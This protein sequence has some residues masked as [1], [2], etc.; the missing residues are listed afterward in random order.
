MNFPIEKITSRMLVGLSSPELTSEE[1]RLLAEY[2][3]AGVI[4]FSR[5]V[6]SEGQL[7][8][9]TSEIGEIFNSAGAEGSVICAD[10]EGGRI[11]VLSSAVGV[12]PSQM[13]M[14]KCGDVDLCKDVY[15]E[16]AGKVKALGINLILAPL[17]D[18]NIEKKN[19]VIGTRSFSDDPEVVS[20]LTACAVKSLLA[21]GVV[22]CVKHFPGHGGTSED[23]HFSLPVIEKTYE[24]LSMFEFTPFID[25][26]SAGV[27]A[28][29]VGHIALKGGRVPATFNPDVVGGWLRRNLSFNGVVITDALEME[30]AF[31]VKENEPAG[32]DLH[33]LE[34]SILRPSN[35]QLF[36]EQL[37][38]VLDAGNDI[39]LYSRPVEEVYAQLMRAISS[40]SEKV[41]FLFESLT[42]GEEGPSARLGKLKEMIA[43]LDKD[44]ADEANEEIKRGRVAYRRVAERV[45]ESQGFSKGEIREILLKAQISFWGEKDDFLNRS[46]YRVI[47]SFKEKV[48]KDVNFSFEAIEFGDGY[49]RLEETDGITLDRDCNLSDLS[50]MYAGT[51]IFR[52][53]TAG[54]DGAGTKTKGRGERIVEL[55]LPTGNSD[56]RVVFFINRRP[57]GESMLV[58]VANNADLVVVSGIPCVAEMTVKV[59]PTVV[60][61]DL[62]DSLVD[63]LSGE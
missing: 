15:M 6:E 25:A 17:A 60:T 44:A 32:G 30:G 49:L 63:V 58:K 27:P 13:A 31:P 34:A 24:Q 61:Y 18:I 5:N 1:R 41:K 48:L 7:R 40:G 46:I 38:R 9:L 45:I 14:G 62:Y 51:G 2:P 52:A 53:Y 36:L 39:L 47:T 57:L 10:H 50:S 22:P 42:A 56:R 20:R 16:T 29:M 11:S 37:I 59:A 28:V 3:P 26:I 55:L 33:F 19:P 43:G 23:S 21:G 54:F 4:L 12:P 35:V 8:G